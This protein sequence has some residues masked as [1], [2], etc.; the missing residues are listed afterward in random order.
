MTKLR[1]LL[2]F[3]FTV[4]YSQ[5][6][7]QQKHELTVKE[8]VE[9]AFKNL[10][11][12]KN[13]QL[14]YQVQQA[15]NKQITGQALPQITGNTN[16]THYL[17]LPQLLFPDATATAVYSIL[18]DEGVRNGSGQPITNVPAPML[19][20]VSF[21]Q[22]WNLTTG[23]TLQQLLFQPD[24]FVG[25]QARKAALDLSAAQIEQVKERV[26]D[27]AYKKY[28]A[29]LIAEKQLEYL[30]ESVQRLEKLYSEA[31]AL[32]KEGFS[33]QLDIDKFQ[34]QLT[35]LRTSRNAVQNVVEISY[36]L[37]K[38][39]IGVSQKDTVV[40][41][42]ELS[43]DKVKEGVLDAE[44]KY[45]DRAEIRTLNYSRDL[46]KLD[47]KRYKLGFIPTVAAM[48][49]Y[50]G[51]GMGQ[52]FF[53]DKSTTWIRSSYVGVNVSI[54]IFDGFQRKYKVQQA[55]LNLQKLENTIDFAKQGVDLEQTVNRASLRISLLNLD[56]QQRN[57]E[58]AQ[59]VVNTTR[60]KLSEGVGS[61]SEVLLAE[62]ELQAARNNYFNALYQ[63]IVSKISYQKALGKLQ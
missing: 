56:A 47:V 19:R 3:V 60:I 2:I 43:V 28:Y 11:D 30:N 1:L 15:L 25:L 53:T 26:K 38:F 4:A 21:Q 8:A 36:A 5:L 7:A 17:Q 35:N 54:P 48:A 16:I 61:S 6:Q 40:L 62:N 51:N 63:A 41:K 50:S 37:L 24:V 22:P 57:M 12:V 59:R 49:N 58:L 23:I 44:F 32:Y 14:D 10:T 18:K 52:K 9:L 39:S 55:K 46:L 29:I 33:E 42:D 13:A 27:S 45:E 34:V 31:E 20:Q